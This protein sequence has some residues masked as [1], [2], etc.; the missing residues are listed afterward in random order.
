MTTKIMAMVDA[1][2]NLVDFT[3]L[4]GQQHDMAGVKPL[5]VLGRVFNSISLRNS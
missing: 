1:L 2:G 3:L 4:K 5:K